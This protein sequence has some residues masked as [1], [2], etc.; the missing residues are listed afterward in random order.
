MG[1]RK[2]GWV[3]V[4]V[5]ERKKERKVSHKEKRFSWWWW[6]KGERLK[7]KLQPERQNLNKEGRKEGKERKCTLRERHWVA[8][9]FGRGTTSRDRAWWWWSPAFQTAAD[10]SP[11]RPQRQQFYHGRRGRWSSNG[12]LNEEEVVLWKKKRKEKKRKHENTDVPQMILRKKGVKAYDT[13]MEVIPF[14]HSPHWDS[15]G[16]IPV[17]ALRNEWHHGHPGCKQ[18]TSQSVKR[19]LKSQIKCVCWLSSPLLSSLFFTRVFLPAWW[20]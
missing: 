6:W 16:Q 5:K 7:K 19:I 15:E 4:K 9:M 10:P 2:H 12:C 1:W 13:D 18:W 17:M 14:N 3:K 20:G 8:E 11:G